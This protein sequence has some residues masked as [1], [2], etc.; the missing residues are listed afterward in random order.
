MQRVRRTLRM[1]TIT[2]E[3]PDHSYARMP[4]YVKVIISAQAGTI[5][6]LTV[7]MYQEYLKDIYF[8]EYVISLFRSNI[9][10]D[11]L[12]SVASISVFSL[13][14]FTLLGSMSSTRRVNREWRLLSEPE[15]VSHVS[16][17][18]VLET[19]EPASKPR[20]TS[21][22][23]RPRKSRGETKKLLHAMRRYDRRSQTAAEAR[24]EIDQ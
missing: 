7:W 8:Q 12:L 20:S 15:E 10:A 3:R 18:P 6:S 1:S 2:I 17:L 23:P 22:R 14:T 4:G 19:V 5:L 13:V 16:S 11:A 24:A 21:R 9:I